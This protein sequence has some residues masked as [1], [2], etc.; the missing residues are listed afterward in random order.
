MQHKNNSKLKQTIDSAID[1]NNTIKRLVN[2]SKENSK[3]IKNLTVITSKNCK[4]INELKEEQ[5][6][7]GILQEHMDTKLNT[8]IELITEPIKKTEKIPAL[9][10]QLKDHELRIR[11][12]EQTITIRK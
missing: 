11:S 10:N 3:N 9:N 5:V 7:F 4:I 2:S 12:I 6:R 8:L 1:E